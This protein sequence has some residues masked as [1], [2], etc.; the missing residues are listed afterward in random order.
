[1]LIRYSFGPYPALLASFLCA[2]ATNPPNQS[3][4]DYGPAEQQRRLALLQTAHDLRCDTGKGAYLDWDAPNE[5]TLRSKAE[6]AS[7]AVFNISDISFTTGKAT[8]LYNTGRFDAEAFASSYGVHF[9]LKPPGY[10]ELLTVY[11]YPGFG[12]SSSDFA[13]VWSGHQAVISGKPNPLEYWGTCHA[14]P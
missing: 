11:A 7:F 12:S 10:V 8:I 5:P 2:C 14:V 13:A 3:H 1:V 6:D 4:A 9:L